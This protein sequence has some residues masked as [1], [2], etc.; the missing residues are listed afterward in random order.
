MVEC[1]EVTSHKHS[2]MSIVL[3]YVHDNTIYERV[4]GLTKVV[5]LTGDSSCDVLLE[6]LGKLKIPMCNMIEKGFDGASNMPGNDTQQQL[7]DAGAA[8]S[9]IFIAFCTA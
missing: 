5:S 4:V 8:L 1:D 3:H 9:S 2:Y 7:I 6:K